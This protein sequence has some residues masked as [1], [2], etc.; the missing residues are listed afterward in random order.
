MREEERRGKWRVR[1]I[2]RDRAQTGLYKSQAGQTTDFER[3]RIAKAQ[4][5]TNPAVLVHMPL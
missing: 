2:K 5:V 3:V 1:R 4:T